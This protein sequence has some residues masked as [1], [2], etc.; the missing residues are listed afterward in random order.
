LTYPFFEHELLRGNFRYN[1]RV[2]EPTELVATAF[3]SSWR[4]FE[5]NGDSVMVVSP[6]GQTKVNLPKSNVKP[7]SV[8]GGGAPAAPAPSAP[9]RPGLGGP[10]GGGKGGPGGSGGATQTSPAPTTP[11]GMGADERALK[12]EWKKD[13][14]INPNDSLGVSI[15]PVHTAYL[16]ATFPHGK[17]ADEIAKA[18]HYASKNDVPNYYKGLEVQR[19]RIVPKGGRMPDGKI[20]EAD[21]VFVLNP[22]NQAEEI[23]RPVAEVDNQTRS[24]DLQYDEK[25]MDRTAG[26]EDVNMMNVARDI[27]RAYKVAVSNNEGF[28]AEKNQIVEQLI[29]YAGPRVALRLPHSVRGEY[30]EVYKQLREFMTA[31]TQIEKDAK[32][33]IPKPPPDPRMG[34]GVIEDPFDPAAGEKLPEQPNQPKNPENANL[35]GPVPDQILLRFVD[36][37]L[38]LKNP[39]FANTFEYRL[40]VVLNNPNY[41]DEKNV[42]DPV[43]AKKQYLTSTGWSP[44]QRITFQPDALVY[45]DERVRKAGSSSDDQKDKAPIQLHKWLGLVETTDKQTVPVGAWWVERML[46]SRGEYIG[47]YPDMP[48]QAGVTNLVQWVS[49]AYDTVKQMV[50]GDV[51]KPT[52]TYDLITRDLLVDFNGGYYQRFRSTLGNKS[53]NEEMPCETLILEADGRLVSRY[54][55]DDKNDTQRKD[56]F[57]QWDDWLKKLPKNDKKSTSGGGANAPGSGS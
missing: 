39:E 3:D 38:Q 12:A 21:M 43:F 8:G 45:S 7:G 27:R 53:V 54:A 10:G 24:P 44:I 31:V 9:G 41:N 1:P 26:W 25:Q 33:Q 17:Q 30:P 23:L 13:N 42:A 16:V 14:E 20:A 46:V 6:A 50:G 36:L 18:L 2:Y 35:T 40:R 32:A 57:T 19:R 22:A 5:T 51:Q 48:G 56:R 29:E 34:K 15:M 49:S 4:V 47:K 28:Y 11:V 52:R 37:D 55:N